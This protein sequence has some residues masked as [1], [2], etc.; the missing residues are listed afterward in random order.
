MSRRTKQDLIRAK[1]RRLQEVGNKHL[2]SHDK[3]QSHVSSVVKQRTFDSDQQIW[4]I[5]F[6]KCLVLS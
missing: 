4:M 1:K 5:L 6:Y 2:Q 3:E